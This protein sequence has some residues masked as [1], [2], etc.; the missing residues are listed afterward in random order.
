MADQYEMSD[1]RIAEVAAVGGF[2]VDLVR[3]WCL[4]QWPTGG[5]HQQWLDTA[6]PS[7]IAAWIDANA[8][9]TPLTDEPPRC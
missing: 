6:P 2:S 1:E 8:A 9:W 3:N 5:A 7:E 4:A